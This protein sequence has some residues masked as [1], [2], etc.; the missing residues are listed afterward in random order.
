MTKSYCHRC[1]RS[2]GPLPSCWTCRAWR[3][4]QTH[5]GEF[6]ISTT[7]QCIGCMSSRRRKATAKH[8][9]CL[10][11]HL[12]CSPYSVKAISSLPLPPSLRS[13]LH[14]GMAF[15]EPNGRKE[16]RVRA[17]G[18]KRIIGTLGRQEVSSLLS[19]GRQRLATSAQYQI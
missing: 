4:S 7:V 9:Y 14:Y 1:R 3:Q 18:E 6:H 10:V 12:R 5:S 17:E 8:A 19:T 11:P 15:E 13:S 16:G 2:I